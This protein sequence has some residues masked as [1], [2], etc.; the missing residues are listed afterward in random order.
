VVGIAT[1]PNASPACPETSRRIVNVTGTESR[2]AMIASSFVSSVRPRTR[3]PCA[4]YFVCRPSSAGKLARHGT[5]QG[6]QKSRTTTLPLRDSSAN[7]V[8]FICRRRTWGAG[9]AARAEEATRRKATGTAR[10]F[11]KGAFS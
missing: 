6:A 3:R 7:G 10:T 11:F 4:P 8:S 1:T 2:N 9:S 5:H